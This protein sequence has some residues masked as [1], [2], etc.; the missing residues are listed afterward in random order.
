MAGLVT[1]PGIS[2]VTE[3]LTFLSRLVDCFAILPRTHSGASSLDGSAVKRIVM[4]PP[5]F[6]NHSYFKSVSEP[7]HRQAFISKFSV[8]AFVGTVLPWLARIQ[9]VRFQISLASPIPEAW[10][11]RI[12][13]RYRFASI[14]VLLEH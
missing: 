7:L 8:E 4:L 5:V 2:Y 9:S 13:D 11:P 3:N 6:N 1:S 12:T 10:W 14:A